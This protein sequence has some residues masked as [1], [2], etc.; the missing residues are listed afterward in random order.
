VEISARRRK[1]QPTEHDSHNS[2]QQPESE[3]RGYRFSSSPF[4]FPQGKPGRVGIPP[5]WQTRQLPPQEGI[6]NAIAQSPLVTSPIEQ[7]KKLFHE[8]KKDLCRLRTGQLSFKKAR[9]KNFTV[10]QD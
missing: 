2:Q 4:P 8:E 6:E 3:L 7:N 9:A 10:R 1:K 5:R